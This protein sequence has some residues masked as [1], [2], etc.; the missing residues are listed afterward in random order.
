MH[1]QVVY[2][3][4]SF[5]LLQRSCMYLMYRCNLMVYMDAVNSQSSNLLRI[6]HTGQC[7]FISEYLDSGPPYKL[8]KSQLPCKATGVM[9]QDLFIN[10]LTNVPYVMGI[11]A[12][13]LVYC[14]KKLGSATNHISAHTPSAYNNTIHI[15]DI[16]KKT[17][18]LISKRF[19]LLVGS[20][21][22][23]KLL[24]TLLF[25]RFF[26]KLSILRFLMWI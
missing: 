21:V 17:R 10:I 24:M 3:G 23:V 8:E 20:T 9:L 26:P 14:G 6:V 25:E 18:S 19:C 13:N 22:L 15:A 12:H 2:H 4:P 16:L 5:L 11:F 7:N 1:N